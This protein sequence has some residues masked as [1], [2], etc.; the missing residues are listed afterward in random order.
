[1]LYFDSNRQNWHPKVVLFVLQTLTPSKLL[2]SLTK[3]DD[4]TPH[5]RRQGAGA[6]GWVISSPNRHTSTWLHLPQSARASL[7]QQLDKTDDH[8]NSAECTFVDKSQG[9]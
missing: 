8:T 3:A 4:R 1:M 9:P 5:D 6:G 7:A 2:Q